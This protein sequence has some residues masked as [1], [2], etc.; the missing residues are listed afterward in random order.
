MTGDGD[1]AD[2][3]TRAPD[4]VLNLVVLDP[5]AR[6]HLVLVAPE[7]PVPEPV[8]AARSGSAGQP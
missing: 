1:P 2:R 3:D 4:L 8:P 7:P 5:Q 6:P